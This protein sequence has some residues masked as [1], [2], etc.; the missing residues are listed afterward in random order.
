MRKVKEI[1]AKAFHN[2]QKPTKSF[3]PY[4]TFV[5]S[6]AENMKASNKGKVLVHPA[7]IERLTDSTWMFAHAILW[8]KHEFS[9]AEVSLAKVYIREYY[10]RIPAETFG[11]HASEYFLEYFERVV[12]TKRYLHRFPHRYIPHPCIWVSKPQDDYFF[13]TRVGTKQ[14]LRRQENSKWFG[15]DLFCSD[16]YS[17]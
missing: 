14:I 9:Q 11:E 15:T 12:E 2:L 8:E 3:F 4:L 1:E 17:F 13:G 16:F 5:T 10:Q 6:N 7:S